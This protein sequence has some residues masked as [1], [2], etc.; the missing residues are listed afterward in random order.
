MKNTIK[1][2]LIGATSTI[3]AAIIGVGAG[4]AF[5]Q[6]TIQNQMNEVLGNVVNVNGDNNNISIND[7]AKLAD[8]Y[9]SLQQE[10]KSLSLQNM[11]YFEDL[12]KATTELNE[13]KSLGNQELKDL[14]AQLDSMPDIQFKNISLSIDGTSIPINNTN[15]SVVV[16]NRTYYSDEFIT[17]LI[18]SNSNMTI[19]DNT[20]FIGQIIKEQ[21]A[22]TDNWLVNSTS[23]DLETN[24]VD[25]YGNTHTQA[26]E[27]WY[28]YDVCSVIYN[29]GNQYS[30]LKCTIAISENAHIKGSGI[31][32]IKADDVVVYTSPTLTKTTAPYE[33]ID[34]PI[35]NCS[36][37]T[38]EYD[39]YDSYDIDCL[40]SDAIVYN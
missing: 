33:I 15:S 24:I 35:N 10:N 23:T 27:F 2:A 25:S 19:Q 16:N 11:K 20:M 5:E 1:V 28:T 9:L 4:Q 7:V 13:L 36:L 26:L 31:L 18:N 14:Q 38:I 8:D 29:L 17:Y 37:L 21:S 3:I 39:M 22:L 30:L 34:I 6:Q 32:T 40:I 12:T